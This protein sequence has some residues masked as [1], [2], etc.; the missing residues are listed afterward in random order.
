MARVLVV[1]GAGYVGSATCA[2]LLD[3]GHDVWILDDL[4]TGHRAFLLCSQATIGSVGDY[5]LVTQL[6]KQEHFDC[7][8]HFGAKA[9]V[10]E[11]VEKPQ[12]YF[13]NNVVQ[14]EILLG[15]ML[16]NRIDNFIFSS[17]CAV[18]GDPNTQ[19]IHENLPR[20]P[21]NPYGQTKLEVEKIL[22]KL[23]NE[24]KLRSIALR[25]FNAAGAEPR[26]RVGEIHS[27]ETHLIPNVLKAA[28]RN[29]EVPI[30]GTDYPTPDGTCI[31]DYIHIWDLASAHVAAMN[32]LL[33]AGKLEN[34]QINPRSYFEVFNLGS[35]TGYSVREIIRASSRIL[36]L[37][38]RIKESIRR[39]GDP[40]RLVADSQ[41]AQ[42]TLG[43]KIGLTCPQ[44]G[45]DPLESIIGSAWNWEKKRAGLLKKAVFLDRDGTL[46]EDPGYLSDPDQLKLLPGVGE[47]LAALKKAGFLLIVI[48]NQSGVGRGLIKDVTLPLIHS[49]MNEL[50]KVWQV[51]I[52]DFYFCSH[53]PEDFC[54]CRKPKPKL[55]YDAILKYGIDLS[56]SVMIG[57]K[58]TDAE[59]GKN[60]GIQSNIIIRTQV[61]HH[62]HSQVDS[63]ISLDTL[64]E[65]V[66]VMSF[67]EAAKWITENQQ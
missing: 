9:L 25:Y 49:K 41:L 17:T 50:L 44:E 55:I 47:G 26:L 12:L 4:S 38:I 10:S 32:R 29:S 37:P 67:F 1:G 65:V 16:E 64:G 22:E 18:F 62:W 31:R 58:I 21:L 20:K 28:F 52:D 51:H 61:N 27:P 2:F 63:N 3:H 60:A 14:T 56:R 42:K 35:G 8:M 46:N 43:F 40:P 45:Y 48:S 59:A 36:K 57:D 23:G 54:Q 34:S 39:P 24:R 30:Y 6:M 13:E 5:S 66:E 53:K 19:L 7:V 33:N 11:S 15:C